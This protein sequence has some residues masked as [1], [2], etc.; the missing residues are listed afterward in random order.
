MTTSDKKQPDG[1]G[2]ASD[3]SRPDI[4]AMRTLELD[5]PALSG[6][7]I[8]AIRLTLGEIFAGRFTVEA[9]IGEGGAGSVYRAVDRVTQLTI[10][11]KLIRTDRLVSTGARDRLV[12]EATTARDIRHP[13]IIAVYDVSESDGQ[14]YITMEYL[15]GQSL[16][17][18]AR[19]RLEAKSECDF[20]TAAGIIGAVLDGVEAAHAAGVIHRDLKPE[21]VFLT[22]TPQGD[23]VK[24]KLLDFGVARALGSPTEASTSATGTVHYM[25]P[26]Q[27][28]APDMAGPS[29]DLYSVSVMF[30][31]LLTG[32]LPQGQWRPPSRG[33]RDVPPGIDR[34]IEAGLSNRLRSRPQTASEYLQA[35]ASLVQAAKDLTTLRRK[36]DTLYRDGN[37][38]PS[39]IQEAWAL[40]LQGADAGD[41][42]SNAALGTMLLQGHGC[43]EDP[44]G[45]RDRWRR[46]AEAGYPPGMTRYACALDFSIGGPEDRAAAREWYRRSAESGD[47]RGMLNIGQFLWD[48]IDAPKDEEGALL[49]IKRAAAAGDVLAPGRLA[50]YDQRLS[51]SAAPVPTSARLNQSD[52]RVS[53]SGKKFSFSVLVQIAKREVGSAAVGGKRQEDGW[54]GNLEKARACFLEAAASGDPDATIAY[55]QF[56]EKD[57]GESCPAKPEEARRIYHSLAENGSGEA[58]YLLG[59]MDRFGRGGAQDLDGAISWYIKAGEAGYAQGYFVTGLA[60]RGGLLH[61]MGAPDPVKARRYLDAAANLGIHPAMDVLGEMLAEGEGGSKD[62]K[63]AAVWFRRA[64]K[65]GWT[66]SAKNLKRYGLD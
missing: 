42:A 47:P 25:A 63:A 4:A 29:A 5:D 23:A 3:G 33:R 21:N 45:A 54:R 7:A 64:L 13:N 18:W 15:E 56:L 43:A 2:E 44:V 35:L 55:A 20:G 65:D 61:W 53:G 52:F 36:A 10:A 49:W 41:P 60:Y 57:F 11:L 14:P 37:G 28:T 1:V 58:M 30:Y 9:L 51:S 6:D 34:L 31:E 19:E 66:S 16:R 24:L 46:A 12:Q 17:S 38:Q 62:L 50:M 32:V 48:G 40:Y 22:A 8:P 39:A 59:E 27:I 26:E